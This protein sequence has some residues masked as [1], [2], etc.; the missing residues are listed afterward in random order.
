MIT[1]QNAGVLIEGAGESTKGDVL[2]VSVEITRNTVAGRQPRNAGD[3][4]EVDRA[5]ARELIA[6]KK[7]KLAEIQ[8]SAAADDGD[9]AEPENRESDL[10]EQ[11]T[12][13]GRPKKK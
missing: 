1:T 4:V 6:L 5:E 3:V 8:S 7:A 11:T 10:D 12:K 9:P 2:K 13:R